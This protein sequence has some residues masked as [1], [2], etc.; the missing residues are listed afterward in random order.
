MTGDP[1]N[2]GALLDEFDLTADLPPDA[3]VAEALVLLKIKS[4]SGGHAI[5]V[6]Q[7]KGLSPA[8]ATALLQLA[9][10]GEETAI[11]ELATHDAHDRREAMAAWLTAN[12][13]DPH[14]VPLHADITVDDQDGRRV[15]RYEAFQRDSDG[16]IVATDEGTDAAVEERTTPLV[17]E[18]PAELAPHVDPPRTR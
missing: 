8:E 12:G 9:I 2:V 16:C 4:P 10:E 14:D 5:H 15:I 13:V 3:A 17:A 18:P 11:R 1:Q 6:V 7:S